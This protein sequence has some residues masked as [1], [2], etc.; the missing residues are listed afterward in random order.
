MCGASLLVLAALA[1]IVWRY[2]QDRTR[3]GAARR[4]RDRDA[5]VLRSCDAHARA[6]SFQRRCSL[7]S[8]AYRL[9]GAIF[10]A[11]SRSRSCS[12]RTSSIACSICTS[13]TNSVAGRQR[14][15]SLGRLDDASSRCSPSARSSSLGYQYL[16]ASRA[17]RQRG[18]PSTAASRAESRAPARQFDVRCAHWFDPREGLDRQCAPRSTTSSWR[19]SASATSF[20]R[21]SAI[22]GRPIRSSTK[23]TS[24]ARAKSICRTCGSTRIRIR[25]SA[26]C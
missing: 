22:G 15:E 25:R 3:S 2:V 16:G 11:R 17:P 23:S 8:R 10:G 26:S 1:L 4:L 9:R 24:R 19:R 14:A 5:R 20:C 13:V 18:R 6:L 12:S 21:S 7:P